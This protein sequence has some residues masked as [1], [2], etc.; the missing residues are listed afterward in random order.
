MQKENSFESLSRH[1][2][3]MTSWAAPV[4]Q[5]LGLFA[6]AALTGVLKAAEMHNEAK[7]ASRLDALRDAQRH[8]AQASFWSPWS[9]TLH[10]Q[11]MT[12]LRRLE[13]RAQH[14]VVHG[15]EV[16]ALASRVGDLVDDANWL[17]TDRVRMAKAVLDAVE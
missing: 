16:S 7:T 14:G 9:R 1:T 8:L 17:T 5:F 2:D 6:A 4:A 13:A 12:D 3:A 10:E 11:V 15:F